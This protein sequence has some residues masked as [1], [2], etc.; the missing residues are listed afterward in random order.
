MLLQL[1]VKFQNNSKVLFKKKIQNSAV[2]QPFKIFHNM[3]HKIFCYKNM[4]DFAFVVK[5]VEY[6]CTNNVCRLQMY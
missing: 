1:F 2:S 6:R 5:T 3:Q 4:Y